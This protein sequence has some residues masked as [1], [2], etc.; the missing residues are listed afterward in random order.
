M[1]FDMICERMACKMSYV[2]CMKRQKGTLNVRGWGKYG[3]MIATDECI[4][5][6]QGAKVM[7]K[8]KQKII[9]GR[10]V[11]GVFKPPRGTRCKINRCYKPVH[12]KNLC[13]VHHRIYGG[14]EH[15][16]N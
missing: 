14:E 2:A 1:N 3:V 9:N 10:Y 11:K 7:K 6:E 12:A 8:H 15:G 5:C 13:E 16:K 4:G